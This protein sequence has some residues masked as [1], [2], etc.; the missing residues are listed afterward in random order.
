MIL[1]RVTKWFHNDFFGEFECEHC[2]STSAGR[3]Y[4]DQTYHERVLPFCECPSCG[5]QSKKG[6]V[7]KSYGGFTLI[8]KKELP[9]GYELPESYYSEE[10]KKS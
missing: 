10:S 6:A 1:K 8:N 2:K 7:K 5:L 4:N 3:G 9:Q